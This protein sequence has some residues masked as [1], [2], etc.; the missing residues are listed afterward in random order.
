MEK[1]NQNLEA[2]QKN[3]TEEVVRKKRKIATIWNDIQ[4]NISEPNTTTVTWYFYSTEKREFPL[5]HLF[6]K[7]TTLFKNK[8]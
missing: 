2:D 5:F 1:R 6:L 8:L 3:S 4:V 7:A